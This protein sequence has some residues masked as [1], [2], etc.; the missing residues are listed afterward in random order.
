MNNTFRILCGA[1]FGICTH[2]IRPS[3]RFAVATEIETKPEN[4]KVTNVGSP[5]NSGSWDTHLDI[6]S[7]PLEDV[8]HNMAQLTN[9]LHR[10]NRILLLTPWSVRKMVLTETTP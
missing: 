9:S 10:N 8:S 3:L 6:V 7:S 2:T 5:V 1:V 4:K